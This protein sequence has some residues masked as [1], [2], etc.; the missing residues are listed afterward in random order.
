MLDIANTRLQGPQT[1]VKYPR[2][3]NLRPCTW[4]RT[5]FEHRNTSPLRK[6]FRSTKR[7]LWQRHLV[8]EYR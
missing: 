4:I 8:A 6:E 7:S 3:V 1:N 2:G 5:E